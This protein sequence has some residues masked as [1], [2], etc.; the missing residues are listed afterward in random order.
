MGSLKDKFSEYLGDIF[1]ALGIDSFYGSTI[2]ILFFALSYIGDFQHWKDLPDWR[3]MIVGS[4]AFAACFLVILS[5]LRLTG[6]L[7]F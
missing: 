4:T 3:K 7:T 6:V 5:L 1:E 2:L